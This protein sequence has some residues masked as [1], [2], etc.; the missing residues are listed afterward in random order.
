LLAGGFDEIH[1]AH[2]THTMTF[3]TITKIHVHQL[4]QIVRKGDP[5]FW[6]VMRRRAMASLA[7]RGLVMYAQL[8]ARQRARGARGARARSPQRW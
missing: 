6:R 8:A 5:A 7:A 3:S 4:D 1:N 2:S